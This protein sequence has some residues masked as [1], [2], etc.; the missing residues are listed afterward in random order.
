MNEHML[1]AAQRL[2]DE[3]LLARINKLALCERGATV[4][5]V[6][7]LAALDARRTHLGE[8]PSSLYVYCR[9][10]LRLSEDA[11][12][13]RAATASAVRRYPVILD[14]LADGSLN[15]TTVRVLRPVLTA[16]NHLAVL[17]DAKH[18]SRKEVEIIAARIN[19]KPDVPSTIRKLPAPRAGETTKALDLDAADPL[20]ATAAT[21]AGSA[22]A[23]TPGPAAPAQT[24]PAHRPSV[25]PLAPERYKV[26]FTVSKETHDKLRR[27][28]ELLCRE[29]PNGDPAVIFDRALDLLLGDAEKRKTA[30]TKKPRRPRATKEGSRHIPRHVRRE[31]WKR[32]EGRCA[33][34]GSSGRCTERRYL[35]C[36][37]IQPHGH[38]GPPTIENI[39]LRCR[40]HNVYE[41]ELVFGRFDA[42]AAARRREKRAVSGQNTPVPERVTALPPWARSE[43]RTHG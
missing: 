40:A 27:V 36:H 12:W 33:F 6:A 32:D 42:S 13:N 24:A 28:Q 4:D 14:S 35:E 29:V 34:V 22:P 9:D 37:H 5:L 26:Q 2:T 10:Q 43:A 3:A 15:V 1:V 31:A 19:P 25:T 8:G 11:A 21:M 20:Q 39:A 23:I 7:H 16:E 30:A 41:S 18:R 38:Q 17:A